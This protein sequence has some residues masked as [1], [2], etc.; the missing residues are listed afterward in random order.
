MENLILLFDEMRQIAQT[1][2]R[3]KVRDVLS[4]GEWSYVAGFVN[5]GNSLIALNEDHL[6][7]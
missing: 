5:P 6:P 1:K 3:K 2:R 7:I 4:I